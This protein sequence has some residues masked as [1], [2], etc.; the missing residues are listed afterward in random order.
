MQVL[1][2]LLHV[3]EEKEPPACA[4]AGKGCTAIASQPARTAALLCLSPV[5]VAASLV[6]DY[7]LCSASQSAVQAPRQLFCCAT[8]RQ[9]LLV[10][11]LQVSQGLLV[12]EHPHFHFMSSL[13][14]LQA[15]GGLQRF[16]FRLSATSFF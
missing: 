7:V 4:L 1:R 2:D 6:A 11:C 9:D 5:L 15:T 8:W 3:C 12:P 16:A 13:H 14:L 10:S